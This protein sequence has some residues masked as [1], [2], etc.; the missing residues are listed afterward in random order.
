MTTPKGSLVIPSLNR[1]E[2]LQETV[3]RF[4]AFPF[5]EW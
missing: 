3:E 2:I 4:L 1:H 5:D